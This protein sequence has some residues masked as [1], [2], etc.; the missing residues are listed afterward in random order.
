FVPFH[1][2]ATAL[3]SADTPARRSNVPQAKSEPSSQAV[4]EL[5]A[6]KSAVLSKAQVIAT[7]GLAETVQP[8]WA[9][10]ASY[11]ERI[12]SLLKALGRD[13][14]AAVR[15]LSAASCSERASDPS[16]AANLYRAAVAD[17]LPPPTRREVEA[18]L[19]EYLT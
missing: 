7:M 11:E 14:E 3:S 2:A 8:L 18:L 9:S 4:E 19:A 15:R 17:P 16:W 1:G 12:A 13:R 6:A 10:A 5:M